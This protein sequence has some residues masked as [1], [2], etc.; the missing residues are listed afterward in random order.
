MKATAD[1]IRIVTRCLGELGHYCTEENLH[2]MLADCCG[3]DEIPSVN[4]VLAA[5]WPEKQQRIE[6]V[7][8]EMGLI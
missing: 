3:V 5:V 7:K 4:E 6:K 8:K 1:Q 2:K